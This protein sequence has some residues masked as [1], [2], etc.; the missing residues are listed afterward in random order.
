MPY[1]AETNNFILSSV[2]KDRRVK[3]TEEDKLNIHKLYVKGV[4]IREIE[5]TLHISRRSIQFILFP[6]RLIENK[7]RRQERGGWKQYYNKEQHKETMKE[8]RHYKHK[9]YNTT[10]GE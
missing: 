6:E 2:D 8:H 7:K 10:I 1:K 4:S 9:I 5:R 3:I